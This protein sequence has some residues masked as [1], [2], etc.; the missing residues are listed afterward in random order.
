MRPPGDHDP[1]R[2]RAAFEKRAEYEAGLP[3]SR[4]V[5]SI[6]NAPANKSGVAKSLEKAG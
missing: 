4:K 1:L 3:T 2:D 5:V 6:G